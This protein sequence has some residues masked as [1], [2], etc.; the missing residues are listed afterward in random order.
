MKHLSLSLTVLVLGAMPLAAAAVD[1][2]P[3]H[4]LLAVESGAPQLPG[5][6]EHS[7]ATGPMAKPDVTETGGEDAPDAAPAASRTAPSPGITPPLQ[8]PS[9]GN[10]P[11]NRASEST[12]APSPASWQSL[13]P[14]SIQ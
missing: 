2:G 11:R 6:Q 10:K 7:G 1:Y 8:A 9:A 4:P 5:V 3:N 12:T 13:L 14:G